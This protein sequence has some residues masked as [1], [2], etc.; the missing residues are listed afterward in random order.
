VGYRAVMNARR[1]ERAM[2]T[3]PLH[4]VIGLYSG[5]HDAESTLER[6]RP[7]YKGRKEHIRAALALRRSVDDS[8]HYRY[9]GLSPGKGARRGLVLG[10]AVGV[11]PGGIGLVLGAVGAAAGALVGEHRQAQALAPDRVNQVAASLAPGSSAIVAVVGDEILPGL[12]ERLAQ[13]G[14]DVVTVAVSDDI[15]E[16]VQAHRDEAAAALPDAAEAEG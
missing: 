10:A 12:Q 3:E 15:V 9:A 16:Q 8:F 6:L 5:E 13:L 11:L 2:E 14:A 4:I 1:K 7:E